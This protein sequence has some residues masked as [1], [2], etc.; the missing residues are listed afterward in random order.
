M[1]DQWLLY[2]TVEANVAV[3]ID[4][5]EKVRHTYNQDVPVAHDRVHSNLIM[6]QMD[7]RKLRGI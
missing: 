2:A 7:I 4:C 6:A 1:V 5:L 3:A